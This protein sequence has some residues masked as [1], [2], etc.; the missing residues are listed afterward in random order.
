MHEVSLRTC[1]LHNGN[2]SILI[3]YNQEQYP[4]I[5]AGG[6]EAAFTI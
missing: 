5:I 4:S 2:L 3:N 6:S 1:A